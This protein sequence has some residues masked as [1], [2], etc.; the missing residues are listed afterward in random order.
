MIFQPID[1]YELLGRFIIEQTYKTL[2]ENPRIYDYR[3]LKYK[4]QEIIQTY[5]FVDK[6]FAMHEYNHDNSKYYFCKYRWENVM[7]YYIT[8]QC[9]AL[10]LQHPTN[11][12]ENIDNIN[13]IEP[14]NLKLLTETNLSSMVDKARTKLK[15]R[16]EE[17]LAEAK[18]SKSAELDLINQG[19]LAYRNQRI[20]QLRRY[21][22]YVR[23]KNKE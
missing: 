20:K 17:Y 22:E 15:Q 13:I 2:L 4:I 6:S 11:P 16:E 21:E 8:Q 9:R 18:T 19:I 10:F 1:N 7:D 12:F 14:Y 3:H 23:N 5:P